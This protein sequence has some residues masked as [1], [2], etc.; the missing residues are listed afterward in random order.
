MSLPPH[1]LT[2]GLYCSQLLV[3]IYEVRFVGVLQWFPADRSIGWKTDGT[4]L[5]F[6][7]PALLLGK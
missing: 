1:K 2:L 5:W 4:V 6:D 7:S 3:G